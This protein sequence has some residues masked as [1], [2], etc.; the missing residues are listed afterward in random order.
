M[1]Q[2]FV[3]GT[4]LAP[5]APNNGAKYRLGCIFTRFF[6]NNKQFLLVLVLPKM[7]MFATKFELLM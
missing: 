4:Q 2:R 7:L 6:A 5:S 1:F 3:S